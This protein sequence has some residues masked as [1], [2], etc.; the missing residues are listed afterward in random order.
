VYPCHIND[1][2]F[3][4]ALVDS[5]LEISA[6]NSKD[7]SSPQVTSPGTNQ[8]LHEDTASKINSSRFG[9]ALYSP[10]D[11]PDANPGCCFNS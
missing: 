2:D 3:A 5:F 1:Y 11:F 9:A 10:S 7:S 4:N 8:D 6:K